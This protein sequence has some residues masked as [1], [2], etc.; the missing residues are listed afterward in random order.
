MRNASWEDILNDQRR[1]PSLPRSR[2]C[3]NLQEEVAPLS[4][5]GKTLIFGGEVK[6]LLKLL[7]ST[8]FIGTVDP[9]HHAQYLT[10]SGKVRCNQN[11]VPSKQETS[12][13][14]RETHDASLT[15]DKE[16][17]DVQ[18][19]LESTRLGT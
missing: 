4:K 16:L 7:R 10:V 19:R 11:Q 12:P 6:N 9:E 2:S 17:Q 13:V 5:E 14:L 1:R 8:D 18:T 3:K 15:L